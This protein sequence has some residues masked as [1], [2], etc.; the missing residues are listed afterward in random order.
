MSGVPSFLATARCL[1]TR[2]RSMSSWFPGSSPS[3]GLVLAVVSS[4]LDLLWWGWLAFYATRRFG[5]IG[6]YVPEYVFFTLFY[7]SMILLAFKEYQNLTPR[8]YPVR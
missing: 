1:G 3:R 7:G 2:V 4:L 6:A 8:I 5:G